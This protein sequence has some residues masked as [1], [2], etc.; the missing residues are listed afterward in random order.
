M[1]MDTFRNWQARIDALSL[2]ERAFLLLTTGLILGYLLYLLLIQPTWQAL[3]QGQAELESLQ[4]RL[5]ALEIR[6]RDLAS[7]RATPEQERHDRIAALQAQL[8]ERESRLQARLGGVL[9]PQQAAQLLQSIL[10]QSRGL[11][12]RQ[13]HSH[14]GAPLFNKGPTA[15]TDGPAVGRYN[16]TLEMEGGYDATRRFLQQ[17]EQ[18]PWTLFWDSLEY[19]VK[20][21]P[22]AMIK[23]N[24]YTLGHS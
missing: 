18:L 20:D 6:S 10:A 14:A 24:L 5:T 16:L 12:L 23:L 9:A 21:H 22:N 15:A 7:G 3:H 8:A 13:L 11:Q 4:T 1:N 19:E 17:V 2:R